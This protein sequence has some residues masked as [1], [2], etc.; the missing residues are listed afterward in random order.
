MFA[1]ARARVR[2]SCRLKSVDFLAATPSVGVERSLHATRLAH[3][4]CYAPDALIIP[5]VQLLLPRGTPHAAILSFLSRG[6]SLDKALRDSA[7]GVLLSV[8]AC[9][10]SSLICARTLTRFIFFPQMLGREASLAPEEKHRL[11]AA[12]G[13]D[14]SAGKNLKD[15]DG[16]L[17]S[18]LVEEL[19]QGGLCKKP[20]KLQRLPG[21]TPPAWSWGAE[22]A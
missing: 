21:A 10:V 18:I 9:A 13:T 4:Y 17:V 5:R 14:A 8:G 11:K 12:F 15:G 16:A 7:R 3:C 2:V 22:T 1:C 6:C 20:H 19:E